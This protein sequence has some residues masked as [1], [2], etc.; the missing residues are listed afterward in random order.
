MVLFWAASK[1]DSVTLL[2]SPLRSYV[3]DISCAITLVYRL[4]YLYS[5][6]FVVVFSF[7][8]LWFC[9]PFV[10]VSSLFLLKIVLGILQG[11]LLWCLFPW[12]Y[13]CFSA[14]FREVFS[15][16]CFIFLSFL[17]IRWCPFPIFPNT[18]LLSKGRDAFWFGKSVSSV[19][20]FCPLF[21]INTTRFSLSSF[22]S[23]YWLYILVE[24]VTVSFLFQ[25]FQCQVP[26][27]CT[28]CIFLLGVSRSLVH[29]QFFANILISTMILL[30]CV[31]QSLPTSRIWYKVNF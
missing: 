15:V 23:I 1:K 27:L 20:T 19:V 12:W 13:F 2:R 7:L 28:G 25:F 24:C 8:S 4:K 5:R 10:W 14:Y 6:L 11:E 22:I 30:L 31:Y 26:F 29:F 21:T 18:F 17:L 3:H 9:C 16:L